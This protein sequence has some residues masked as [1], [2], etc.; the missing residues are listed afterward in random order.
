MFLIFPFFLQ[1]KQCYLNLTAHSTFLKKMKVEGISVDLPGITYEFTEEDE[2]PEI[3]PNIETDIG[4]LYFDSKNICDGECY[5]GLKAFENPIGIK[6]MDTIVDYSSH[7]KLDNELLTERMILYKKMKS[8]TKTISFKLATN[9]IR[10]FEFNATIDFVWPKLIPETINFPVLQ[11]G[12]EVIKFITINNPSDQLVILHYVLH[13]MNLHGNRIDLPGIAVSSCPQCSLTNKSV[14]SFP[15]GKQYKYG[16]FV[17]PKSSAKIAIVFSAETPGTYSTLLYVRNNLTI[18]EAVWITAKAVVPQFK[19]GS[20]KSGSTTALLFNIDDK[21]L[22]DCDK[23]LNEKIES[24]AVSTKRI[25]TARN[26][27][28]VPIRIGEIKIGGKLCEGFGFKIMDCSPFDL[29]P[30]GSKK[31]EIAFTPDFTLA[32]VVR[33]LELETSMGYSVNYTLL[34]TIPPHALGPCGKALLRPDWESTLKISLTSVLAVVF[35]FSLIAAFLDADKCIKDHLHNLSRDRGPLQPTLDLRQIGLRSSSIADDHQQQPIQIINNNS[36]QNNNKNTNFNQN[37]NKKKMNLNKKCLHEEINK[38]SWTTEF[39]TK[40]SNV[41]PQVLETIRSTTKSVLSTTKSTDNKNRRRSV[42]P[43]TT[44]KIII[45]QKKK[46]FS[47]NRDEE[48]TSSTTTESS[49]HSEE[50]DE[51]PSPPIQ[52]QTEEIKIENIVNQNLNE[53]I[54][55]IKKKNLKTAVKKTRSLPVNY[56]ARDDAGQ[57]QAKTSKPN[58]NISTNIKNTR[59]NASSSNSS[60]SE[61]QSA[62]SSSGVSLND[63]SNS[64]EPKKV[65]YFDQFLNIY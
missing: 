35:I 18:V 47:K 32:R 46:E 15:V 1:D 61:C 48:E 11:I 12:H 4:R 9:Q 3:L 63:E 45:E 54:C 51:K 14:F 58:I 26:V 40:L 20:R 53:N 19:F 57:P 64:P 56:E 29:S 25:F 55:D 39:T 6:W 37:V 17:N 28:E 50:S 59:N 2:F 43:P 27:G 16:D 8:K 31:I 13:D 49:I 65:I 5:T 36:P 52:Q 30:N 33:L 23:K 44:N 21:H 10:K 42:T 41:K 38:K 22:R 7:R 24:I 60:G 34:S 62:N